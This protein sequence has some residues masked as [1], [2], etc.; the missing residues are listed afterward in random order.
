MLVQALA[1]PA[2][3]LRRSLVGHV[4]SIFNDSARGERPVQRSAD[5]LF[6]RGSVI[7]RVHGDVTSMMVGG[8]AALLLQMLHPAALAG[9]LDYSNFRK[10]MLGRLRR[11]A[12]FIATTTYGERVA[13]E[14]AIRRVR[15]IHEHVAGTTADGTPYAASD[16]RLLAWVHTAEAVCFLDAWIKYGEPLMSREDQD[17]YFAQFAL[18]ARRLGADPVPETRADALA[19]IEQFRPELRGTADAREVAGLVLNQRLHGPAAAAAQTILTQ[20]AIDLLP[21]WAREMLDLRGPRR[22]AGLVRGT[23]FGMAATLRWAFAADAP[24]ARKAG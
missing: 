19:L 8:M 21:R 24:G 5:A 18:I 3:L 4:R 22:S 11:T 16:P 15:T 14:A 23:T 1:N 7:W 9:V 13:A 2:R 20:A 12:R 6:D 10:D 17:L